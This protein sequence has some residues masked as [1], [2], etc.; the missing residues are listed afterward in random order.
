MLSR[1]AKL[2][3]CRAPSSAKTSGGTYV[4]SMMG[5]SMLEV[6]AGPASTTALDLLPTIT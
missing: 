2:N 5:A 6:R 3:N 4:T 1:V